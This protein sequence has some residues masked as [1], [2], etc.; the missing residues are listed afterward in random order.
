ML[1]PP[2]IRGKAGVV[3]VTLL[4]ISRVLRFLIVV[5]VG[6]FLLLFV[7]NM[8]LHVKMRLYLQSVDSDIHPVLTIAAN[9][10][11]VPAGNGRQQTC[12]QVT[13][14]YT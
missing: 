14:Q 2:S 5:V 11:K 12:I 7:C 6:F 1:L 4:L 13:Y 8:L 3:L 9:A 10:L